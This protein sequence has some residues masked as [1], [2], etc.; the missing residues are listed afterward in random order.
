[1]GSLLSST[2]M[3]GV[4]DSVLVEFGL[5]FCGPVIFSEHLHRVSAGEG[6]GGKKFRLCSGAGGIP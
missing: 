3:F 2:E 6:R 5:V 4:V 1:M